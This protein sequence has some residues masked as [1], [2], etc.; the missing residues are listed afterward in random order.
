MSSQICHSISEGFILLLKNVVRHR[1][2]N[3]QKAF[4]FCQSYARRF[5]ES[6]FW[7][8]MPDFK[9]NDNFID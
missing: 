6:I 7:G 5:F 8:T 1:M 2:L 9:N 3:L 4:A